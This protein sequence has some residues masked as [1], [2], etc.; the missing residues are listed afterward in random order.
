MTD[1]FIV[2]RRSDREVR[3][4]AQ[5]ARTYLGVVNRGRVDIAACLRKKALWT[6]NGIKRLVVKVLSDAEMGSADGMTTHE[7]DEVIIY[8][9]KSVYDAAILGE[10]R[11]RNTVMHEFGHA[12][13]HDR[14]SMPRISTGNV[15]YDWIRP[16][17]SA[18]HQAKIF[19]A[20]FLIDDE[21]ASSLYSA[22]DI[23]IQF[24]VSLQ[25]AEIYFKERTERE[26]RSRSAENIRK[27]AESVIAEV[28]HVDT[29]SVKFLNS[30]C[31]QCGKRTLF[32]V[33]P[34][35]MCH[36]CDAVSDAFQDGDDND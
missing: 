11:A 35:F 32:P 30:P 28:K 27:I 6:V 1:D 20:A 29:H 14:T 12:V 18:E 23:S 34:K 15:R 10:G 13:V 5:K 19:A 26:Q 17:E 8:L 16:Y 9:K 2:K 33:G 36:S 22:E 21:I 24:W 31:P 4:I 25:C 3:Q 7:K